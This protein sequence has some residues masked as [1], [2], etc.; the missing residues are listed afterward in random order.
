VIQKI[1]FFGSIF[2]VFI[3]TAAFAADS[4]TQA[5]DTEPAPPSEKI[6]VQAVKQK[7]WA[8]GDEGE[9]RVVRKR[10]YTKEGR[11]EVGGFW[12]A[13]SGDPFL[14][15]H[16]LGGTLG[17]HFS[18]LL[19]AEVLGWGNIVSNSSAQD[20]FQAQQHQTVN[21]NRPK[22][23]VAGEVNVN[24]I[25]GKLSLL[26]KSIIYFDFLVLGGLGSTNTAS[27]HYIT[28]LIGLSKYM[29]LRIDWRLTYY[30]ENVLDANT[31]AVV[32]QNSNFSNVFTLGFGFF[33]L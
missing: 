30:K 12:G 1:G 28:P 25:Y 15:I 31:G 13:T 32:N 2:A 17:Y 27:G 21:T 24:P 20:Q 8:K 22:S 29:A 3:S 26:G 19:G 4:N 14:S 5:S 18:E 23:L 6:D 16:N 9:L 10:L 33:F 11:M 7:Y